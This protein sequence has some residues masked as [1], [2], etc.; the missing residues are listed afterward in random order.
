MQIQLMEVRPAA[1]IMLGRDQGEGLEVLLVR[2]NKKLAFAG[3]V[4]VFP[5][6]KIEQSEFSNS[7]ND[8]DAAKQAALR[9]TLE[10]TSLSVEKDGLIYFRHWTTPAVEPK[11]FATWFFFASANQSQKKVIIDDNEIKDYQWVNPQHAL[12]ELKNGERF[13]MPPTFL[14][15]LLIRNCNSVA[16]AQTVLRREPVVEVRPVMCKREAG[17]D[18]LYEGDAGYNKADASIVGARHRLT[19]EPMNGKIQF[20][21]RD[22]KNVLPV[23]GG[24][25]FFS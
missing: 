4:W 3:G 11:R 6:G 18:L 17:V 14:S 2:R 22:C 15:L 8:L 10:E 7:E 9:E 21:F 12:N 1:T 23:T 16:E 5:G 20:Q 25:L 19:L 24:D 13:L